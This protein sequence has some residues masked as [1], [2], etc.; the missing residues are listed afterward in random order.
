MKVAFWNVNMGATS[1]VDR[2][3]TFKDWCDEIAPDLLLLEEVGNTLQARE[4]GNGTNM[5]DWSSGHTR[6]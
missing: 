1:F 3:N 4:L 2:L 5:S 6:H